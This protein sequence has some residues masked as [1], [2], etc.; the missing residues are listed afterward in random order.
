M[1][2]LRQDYQ[3]FTS[4]EAEIIIVA[5]DSAQALTDYWHKEKLPF[6]GLSDS[7]HKV[8]DNYK[9]EV[10]ILKIGRMPALF[11]IDKHGVIRFKHYSLS[12]TDIVPNFQLFHLLD[13]INEK[14]VSS[15]TQR[16]GN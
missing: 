7:D 16:I 1:A 15:A 9:Q 6:I 13:S 8:A 3:E 11:V 5:P 4:R 14:I 10:N 12:S 2:Q